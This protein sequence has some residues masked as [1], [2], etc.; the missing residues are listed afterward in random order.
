MEPPEGILGQL[1]ECLRPPESRVISQ[2]P[3]LSSYEETKIILSSPHTNQKI[4]LILH[5]MYIFIL[6]LIIQLEVI[7][8]KNQS[9]TFFLSNYPLLSQEQKSMSRLIFP[10]KISRRSYYLI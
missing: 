4:C 10:S 7:I 2:Y 1:A 6:K 5:E 8:F 3:S 9:I